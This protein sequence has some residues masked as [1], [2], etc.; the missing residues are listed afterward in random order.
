[1]MRGKAKICNFLK[2][3]A[4]NNYQ[5][6]PFLTETV[7]SSTLT[8]LLLSHIIESKGVVK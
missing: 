6:L 8:G 4:I 2:E 3:A 7:G 5:I 1:M